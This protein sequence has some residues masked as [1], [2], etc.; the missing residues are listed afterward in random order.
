M[1]MRSDPIETMPKNFVMFQRQ[2][3]IIKMY[4]KGFKVP[5]FDNF[6]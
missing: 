6:F 4:E 5:R 2:D 1:K 3:S